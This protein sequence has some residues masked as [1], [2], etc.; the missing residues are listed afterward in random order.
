MNIPM[1]NAIREVLAIGDRVLNSQTRE[2]VLESAYHRNRQ[3]QTF[4]ALLQARTLT[5]WLTTEYLDV[6]DAI[7]QPKI[8]L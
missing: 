1:Q 8:G 3:Q 6:T 4:E 5:E 2:R 7:T